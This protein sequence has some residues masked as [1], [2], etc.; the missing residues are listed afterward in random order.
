[1]SA[2]AAIEAAIRQRVQSAAAHLAGDLWSRTRMTVTFPAIQVRPAGAVSGQAEAWLAAER[3]DDL[4]VEALLRALRAPA[5]DAAAGVR[6]RLT[7]WREEA[8]EATVLGRLVFDV[9]L[10]LGD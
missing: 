9:D 4:P 1:M 7:G 6:L 3:F 2:R 8:G 5:Y 10:L